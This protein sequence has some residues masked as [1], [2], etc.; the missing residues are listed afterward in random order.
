M[1]YNHTEN[2]SEN[3]D[4]EKL[5]EIGSCQIQD[6]WIPLPPAV[7]DFILLLLFYI[8]YYN[9]IFISRIRMSFQ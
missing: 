6:A 4:D 2:N 8:L 9:F 3:Y 7:R 5:P 1:F